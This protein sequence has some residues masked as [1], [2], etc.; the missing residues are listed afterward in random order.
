MVENLPANSGDTDSI[1]GLQ[2][3]LRWEMAKHSSILA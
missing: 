3:P 1:S 2:N